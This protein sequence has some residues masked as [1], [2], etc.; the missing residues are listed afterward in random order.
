MK[1]KITLKEIAQLLDRSA[2]QL[3]AGSA[4]A[5]HSARQLA[6]QRQQA[7]TATWVDRHG[8]LHAHGTQQHRLLN[9]LIA[10]IVASL[11]LGNIVYL[12]HTSEH[13]HGDIDIAILTDDMPIDVYVD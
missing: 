10:V 11:L 13:S 5:L 4:N 8:L 2:N 12:Y 3:N 6:L 9:W 7:S 1:S